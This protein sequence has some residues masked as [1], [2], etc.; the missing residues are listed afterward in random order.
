MVL[1]R[2]LSVDDAPATEAELAR[3]PS[4]RE[5][6]DR[7]HEGKLVSCRL[8]CAQCEQSFTRELDVPRF[9]WMEIRHAARQLLADIHIL[10]SHYGWSER[11]I[12]AMSPR[13][14]AAYL[15]MLSA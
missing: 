1:A 12:A 14:R 9:V 8:T 2:C 13:R 7:L 11:E 4:V 6:F 5:Q 10:A 3:S 15:E